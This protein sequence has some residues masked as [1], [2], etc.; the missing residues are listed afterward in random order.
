MENQ[1]QEF[2]IEVN[3]EVLERCYQK[4]RDIHE[5]FQHI[6]VIFKAEVKNFSGFELLSED[7]VGLETLAQKSGLPFLFDPIDCLIKIIWRVQAEEIQLNKNLIEVLLMAF[8]ELLVVSKEAASNRIVA[9]DVISRLCAAL[10][11]L[12][13]CN[14]KDLN[15]M[16]LH[17]VNLMLGDFAN[18][19]ESIEWGEIAVEKRDE[20]QEGI[21]ISCG[22]NG[23]DLFD[24]EPVSENSVIKESIE[25]PKS[26]IHIQE[27]ESEEDFFMENR[28]MALF[29]IIADTVEFRNPVWR[30]R[31]NSI[32]SIALGMNA[33]ARNP[34]P[35]E[36]LE[37]AVYMRD[38]GMLRLTDK[39]FFQEEDLTE[40][41][42]DLLYSH[43]VSGYEVLARLGGWEEAAKI[44]LQ[45]QE[46]EDGSGYPEGLVGEW[47]CDGAKI[48]AIC[49][50]FFQLINNHDDPDSER[51]AL[52]AVAE[53]NAAKGVLFD[54]KLVEIFN[55]TM[56]IQKR[57][58][59]P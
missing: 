31:D 57:V 55:T 54:E 41:E 45:H 11:P 1:E 56:K 5:K 59:P 10:F 21:S 35:F 9:K 27:D 40:E 52:R 25:F 4:F 22:E 44:V 6:L 8:D 18:N 36:Q 37:A 43:P 32:I 12:I 50:T 30:K 47:I 29:R 51:A 26:D 13:T 16:S 19:K 34:V 38:F 46:R 14:N 42:L 2:N 58:S 33:V 53:I 7:L 23:I 20:E 28:D 17:A 48:L 3:Q 15:Q 24:E 39:L 49:D